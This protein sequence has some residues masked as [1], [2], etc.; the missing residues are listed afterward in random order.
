MDLQQYIELSVSLRESATVLA[1]LQLHQGAK[2][3]LELLNGMYLIQSKEEKLI[4]QQRC[5]RHRELE[6]QEELDFEEEDTL[7]LAQQYFSCKEFQRCSN[8]LSTCKSVK[9][10]F[11]RLYSQYLNIEKTQQEENENIFSG[12]KETRVFNLYTDILIELESL[13]K[14]KD[15]FLYY[16]NG[17]ILMKEN[18][19]ELAQECFIQSLI[20]YPFNWSCWLDLI[21][22]FSTFDEAL[23]VYN[24]LQKNIKFNTVNSSG[25]M[26]LFFKIV[27]NQE[28]FQQSQELYNDLEYLLSIFPDFSFLKTQKALISYHALD[29]LTAEQ[30]FD[31]ILVQD[32]LR[33]DDMD[34]YSNILYVMEKKSK[35]SFL[36]QF[37]SSIDKFRPETCCIIANYYSLKF[38]H[39]KSIMYYK[40]ALTLN[41]DCLSAWT[42]MG[43]EFVELK[44]SHAAIESY[45]RAIDINSKDYRAWYGLG[46]LYE[47]LDM[48]LYSLYYY[49]RACAL[50]P[51]DKRMWQLLGN[52]YEK[53]EKYLES[54]KSYEKLLNIDKDSTILYKLGSLHSAL[55]DNKQAQFYMRLCV[56]EE[57]NDIINDDTSKLKL[58]LAKQEAM[59]EN[60]ESVYK[61]ASDLQHGNSHDL[62]EARSLATEARLKMRN[63]STNI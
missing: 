4:Y 28:F 40:R 53:L 37:S 50:K 33:L 49:Q 16:L 29:Y 20:L 19:T 17:I 24:K 45:R 51:M 43:H 6:S 18:N 38:E 5:R 56:L 42:L 26:L 60:W 48:H 32:P 13:K 25:I 47:F 41:K 22:S 8:L 31:D 23:T 58:W 39:E 59:N 3:S 1:G 54:I 2:W 9:L 14:L 34:T 36:L 10:Q 61:Y 15:P 35:L 57:S 11:I 46:Q 63:F 52:C 55:G 27:I 21:S 12:T 30:I 44:N 62:E 7:M